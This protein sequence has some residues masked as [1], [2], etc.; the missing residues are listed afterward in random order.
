MAVF[1]VGHGVRPIAELVETLADD[2]AASPARS[3]TPVSAHPHSAARWRPSQRARPAR[4]RLALRATVSRAACV[5]VELSARRHAAAV[6]VT[7]ANARLHD[8]PSCPLA[9]GL[10]LLAEV[11]CE[12]RSELVG[13]LR[14]RL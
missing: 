7:R 14:P 2:G 12:R 11:T 4:E 5:G 13:V 9:R 1:T 3:A 8:C 10:S 6:S